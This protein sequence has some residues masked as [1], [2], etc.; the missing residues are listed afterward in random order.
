MPK[1][2]KQQ[3]QG[4]LYYQSKQCIVIRELPQNNAI[5]LYCLLPPIWVPFNDPWTTTPRNPLA[6]LTTTADGSS[7]GHDIAHSTRWK[8]ILSNKGLKAGLI[9]GNQWLLSPDHKAL[10]EGGVRL[11]SHDT[12]LGKKRPKFT[13]PRL[14]FAS[15]FITPFFLKG[16]RSF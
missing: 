8:Q 3:P 13:K 1:W 2:K 5:D 16:K 6:S 4:S 7:I 12:S 9:K 10:F 11:T 14:E 15:T